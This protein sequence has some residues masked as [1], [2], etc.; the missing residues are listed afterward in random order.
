MFSAEIEL[1]FAAC[2]ARF[3]FLLPNSFVRLSRLAAFV[4][5]GRT[6]ADAD[7]STVGLRMNV[8]AQ[9][10]SFNSLVFGLKT[11]TAIWWQFFLLECSPKSVPRYLMVLKLVDTAIFCVFSAPRRCTANAISALLEGTPC[12]KDTSS[13]ASTG[14]SSTEIVASAEVEVDMATMTRQTATQTRVLLSAQRSF[15][16]SVSRNGVPPYFR[17][18][19]Q[20]L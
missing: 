4:T 15:G 19:R 10:C 16:W 5:V 7:C 8:C 18:I 14:R 3:F 2:R 11:A 9:G 17:E 6:V 12:G 1:L 13:G 20:I